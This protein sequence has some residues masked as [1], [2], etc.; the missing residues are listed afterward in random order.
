M[1][2][3]L[4]YCKFLFALVIILV[5]PLPYLAICCHSLTHQP[6]LCVFFLLPIKKIAVSKVNCHY[7]T[8]HVELK[9]TRE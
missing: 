9:L 2:V 5:F 3:D 1:D 7:V 8:V 4:T 6:P